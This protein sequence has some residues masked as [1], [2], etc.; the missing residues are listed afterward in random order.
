MTDLEI[1][2]VCPEVPQSTTCGAFA[3]RQVLFIDGRDVSRHT[4]LSYR[5]RIGAATFRMA[6][7]ATV[8]TEPEFRMRGY[9]RRVLQ[10]SLRWMDTGG[11]EIA[12]LFGIPNFYTKVGFTTCIR[13][14]GYTIATGHAAA[15]AKADRVRAYRAGDL[16]QVRSLHRAANATLAATAVR[17]DDAWRRVTDAVG[18]NTIVL[19]RARGIAGYA[20]IGGGNWYADMTARNNQNK[21]IVPELA[22]ADWAAADG[23][24]AELGSRARG[25]GKEEIMFL[26]PP[27]GPFAEACFERGGRLF[28]YITPNGGGMGRIIDLN[29]FCRR[30]APELHRRLQASPL[31][32][33]RIV[34]PITTD[35][36]GMIIAADS[37]RL[38]VEAADLPPRG[39]I[40]IPQPVLTKLAFGYDEPDKLLAREGVRLKAAQR[41]LL[42]TIFPRRQPYF[43]ALDRF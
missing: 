17:D 43:W 21:L 39:C 40:R 37:G 14:T 19:D 11:Y 18:K 23:L 15:A 33:E 1:A 5:V 2:T 25:A 24:L 28:E 16:P 29:R 41:L 7:I 30:L 32:A 34:L 38:R 13:E 42:C 20:A 27:V 3:A 4:V 35:L 9:A 22:C 8:G 6:G 10:H 31:A 26:V 36:G 12:M